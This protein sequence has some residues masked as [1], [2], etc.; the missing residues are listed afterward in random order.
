MN[1]SSRKSSNLWNIHLF[2]FCILLWL[3]PEYIQAQTGIE[4][5]P[6]YGYQFGGYHPTYK[7][8]I[9]ISDTDNFG[10]TIDIATSSLQ[11]GTYVELSYT[12]QFAEFTYKEGYYGEI[13]H[14]FD[15]AVEYYHIGG[16]YEMDLDAKALKGFGLFGLGA[17]RFAPNTSE[18]KEEWLFSAAFGLGLKAYLS[19]R[20]GFR[21]QGRLLMPMTW[22]GGG[23]W[24][25]TGGCNI[26]VGTGS[27]IVQ[28]DVSAG[29]IIRF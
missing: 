14:R 17:T 27:V 21:F 16:L 9:D 7:G 20:F 11:R 29:L 6:S 25:S 2:V 26:G 10:V 23:M 3:S 1:I 12:R 8:E 18:Y 24:C 13:K 28:A 22:S 4:I 15:M 5:T 19:P